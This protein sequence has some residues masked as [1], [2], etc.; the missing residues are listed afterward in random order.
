MLGVIHRDEEGPVLL[1]GW[2]DRIRPDVITLELSHYGVR[3]RRERGE[4][5]KRR[6]DR[7]AERLRKNGELCSEES[8]VS[9]RL[10]MDMP[11]EYDVASRFG[12]EHKVPVH[13]IDMDFFSYV[14]LRA[15]DDLLSE[16]NI[17]KALAGADRP[18]VNQEKTMA[19]LYFEKGIKT[20]SYDREM[21]IRDRYMSVKIRDLM[22]HN[23]GERFLHV[24]GWQH[25]Q[26]PA[27][28]YGPLNPTKVFFYDKTLCL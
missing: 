8:L 12:A 23:R 13:L 2:L 18:I 4:G 20:S 21:Y 7:I 5:Y 15:V 16:E 25:L 10:Y 1:K 22:R 3:F 6:I 9:L 19:R 28:L 26:D 17:E 24:C 11:Y 27:N 14:K